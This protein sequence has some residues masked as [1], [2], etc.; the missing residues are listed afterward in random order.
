[1]QYIPKELTGNVNVSK[2]DPVKEFFKLLTGLLVIILSVYVILGL[3]VD[4][5]V[6]LIP[7]KTEQKL[8]AYYTNFYRTAPSLQSARSRLQEITND[9]A[10]DSELS[11]YFF[12]VHVVS[13]PIANAFAVPGNNI[14]VLSKMM[15]TVRSENEMAM[16][17]A[18][19]LAHFINRDHLKV[20][21]RNLV[22]WFLTLLLLGED[23]TITEFTQGSLLNVEMK[24]SRD[25]ERRADE[26]ALHALVRRYGHAGGA[27]DFFET[28][29]E[30][31]G[32][33]FLRHFR[34]THPSPESRID[35]LG[36]LIEKNGYPVRENL[37]FIC[38]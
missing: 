37:P 10:D 5:I 18:H 4:I 1:M 25:Q 38:Q 23:N 19:E 9:L 30:H 22:V 11:G 31:E 26:W 33:I 28:L 12:T 20:M 21:G 34:R 35:A 32:S 2:K 29:K 17:L 24:F 3:L 8:G 36:K 7:F 13:S 16:I 6:P 27:G 14:V 15:E